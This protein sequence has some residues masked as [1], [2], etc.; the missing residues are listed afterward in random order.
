MDK[1]NPLVSIVLATYNPDLEWLEA[2]LISLN[3]QTYSNLE[4]IILDDCSKIISFESI[5]KL[6]E[7]SVTKLPFFIYRN[8]ENLGSNRTF[9]KL[10]ELA[11][12][13]YISYCDQDD[14]W[15]NDKI[16]ILVTDLESDSDI[17]LI[18]SD[19]SVI[20][21]NGNKTADSLRDIRKRLKF[22]SG[23]DLTEGLITKNFVV[24]CTMIV[25]SEVAKKAIPFEE[26]MVH[27]QWIALMAS[28][29]GKIE[30]KDI[31]LIKYRQHGYNQ[32][33]VMTGIIDKKTYYKERIEYYEKRYVSLNQKFKNTE[34]EQY[35]KICMEW[36]N[37]RNKYFTNPNLE[38]L[39]IMIKYRKIHKISVVVELIL[40]FIPDV[41]FI[42]IINIAKRGKL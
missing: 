5:R 6:I 21:S 3:N 25:K 29:S 8:E 32:T 34:L 16:E 14:I 13:K 26:T 39:R 23:Y 27:D 33:G 9:Q 30:Y 12:G 40:P 31:P 24:G 35:L 7:E 10:T 38:S 15:E 22:L 19:L 20:D 37:A 28:T 18:Y 11:T 36:M 2:Q 41:L 1:K 17:S 42:Y 4:L